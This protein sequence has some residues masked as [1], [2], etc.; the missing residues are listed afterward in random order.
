M[1][2]DVPYGDRPRNRFDLFLPC[3]E[4]IGLVL[5]VHGGYWL[6]LDKGLFSY[7]ARG[8]LA[9]DL[10]VAIPSYTLCPEARIR[11]ITRE[12]AAAIENA[13]ARVSGPLFL[14][15]HSA[16]GHLVTRMISSTSPLSE[17]TRSRIRNTLSISGVHDL[18]PLTR[19]AMNTELR[20]SEAESVSESPALL[21]PQPGSRV[22]CWVGASERAEFLRQS[23]LLANIWT[24]VGAQ[25]SIYHEPDRHHFN[26][27][28]GL[29]DPTHPMVQALLD[30]FVPS[31]PMRRPQERGPV[32]GRAREGN[33]CS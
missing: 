25:T 24:G 16:G 5:F 32:E 6:E 27:V 23:D 8:P 28:D 30:G 15:G 9:H 7:L 22:S 31:R 19:T 12:I 10:A 29:A 26:I 4:A 11:D 3:T 14:S 18:R 2:L 20:L 1:L 33:P 13:A 17:G 21:E